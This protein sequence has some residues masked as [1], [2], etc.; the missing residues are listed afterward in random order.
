[1]RQLCFILIAIPVICFSQ[2]S[3]AP[4]GAEWNY[5]GKSEFHSVEIG[6][7]GNHLNYVVEE[8][9]MVEGRDCSLIRAYRSTNLDTVWRYTGDSLIVW[10]NENKVYFQQDSLFLLLFDFGAELGDTIIRYDP[11]RRGV[12]SGTFYEESDTTIREMIQFVSQILKVQT[13]S[14]LDPYYLYPDDRI[15]EGVG[16]LSQSLPGDYFFYTANGCD[17]ELICYNNGSIDYVTTNVFAP[18]HPSCDFNPII[19]SVEDNIDNSIR[20]Y[21][22]PFNTSVE[23]E[24]DSDIKLLRIIG[25]DGRIL[26]SVSDQNYILTD[27]LTDGT[28]VLHIITSVGFLTKKIIKL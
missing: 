15:L 19:D 1:M 12:F 7:S 23:V 3:Y 4:L 26:H 16:S 17:G 10:E 28:Y 5:E 2:K 6:C 13:V 9:L 25:I 21:P 11:Y 27:N 22:N 18:S 20:V 8:E 24:A 14:S